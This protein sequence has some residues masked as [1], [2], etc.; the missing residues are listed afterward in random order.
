MVA[1]SDQVFGTS[2]SFC[3]KMIAPPSPVIWAVRVSQATSSAGS[4][5]F[6][7]KYRS[8]ASPR[9]CAFFWPSALRPL[10][11]DL[12]LHH[13]SSLRPRALA[14]RG[15]TPAP[16]RDA[17]HPAVRTAPGRP[18]ISE[19]GVIAMWLACRSPDFAL[20]AA[21]PPPAPPALGRAP[22]RHSSSRALPV[23]RVTTTYGALRVS[24]TQHAGL[25]RAARP[26]SGLR[27]TAAVTIVAGGLTSRGRAQRRRGARPHRACSVRARERARGRHGP[28][29]PRMLKASAP[30]PNR[31]RTSAT[32]RSSRTSITASRRSRIASSRRPAR[33]RSARRRRSSSTTW[34]S[35]ASAGS[36]S[37]PRPSA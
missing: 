31:T 36:P 5:P 16:R 17:R 33:S 27:P 13:P 14:A 1:S 25:F 24:S 32:S 18:A 23:N 34:S 19:P 12:A 21:A 29:V 6:V 30:W 37:R 11:R 8:I 4:T 10:P 2:T 35:S 3:S 15:Q 9:R 20:H 22:G 26:T 28:P 7:V